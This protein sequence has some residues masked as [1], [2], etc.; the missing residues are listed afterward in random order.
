MKKQLVKKLSNKDKKEKKDIRKNMHLPL[1]A[2]QSRQLS[3]Y[4]NDSPLD[5]DIERPIVPLPKHKNPLRPIF[6]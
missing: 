3:Y 1:S 6:Q 4:V 2:I 5:L